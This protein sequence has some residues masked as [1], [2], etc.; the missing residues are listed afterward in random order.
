MNSKHN[1]LHQKE[2]Y[3]FLSPFFILFAVFFLFPV[4]YSAVIS[5][6][7]WNGTGK[8]T[9]TGLDNYTFLLTGD[10]YFWSSIRVTSFILVFGFLLQHLIAIPLAILLNTKALKGRSVFQFFYF[11]PYI[12]SAVSFSMFIQNI[13]DTNN[14]LFNYILELI[15]S[16]RVG[17]LTENENIPL[18]ISLAINWRTI[19]FNTILYL[20]A[21]QS[22]NP[23]MYEAAEI[24]GAGLITKHLKITVPAL[25]PFVFFTVTISIING[26]QVFDEPYTMV[27]NFANGVVINKAG[28]STTLY[29]IYLLKKTGK[30]GRGNAVA[31]LLFIFIFLFNLINRKLS[32]HF[33]ID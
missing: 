27:N 19:G 3:L 7:D 17:W 33:D 5:F 10:D 28:L 9:F 32:K 30:W 1:N 20:A 31:W 25:L 22:I 18:S 8:F 23:A 15:G 2:P 24:D 4:I 14:G 16:N 13:L 6:S 26:M 11:L 21:L 12:F 29:V